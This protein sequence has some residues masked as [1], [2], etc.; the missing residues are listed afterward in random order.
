MDLDGNLSDRL[1]TDAGI[2]QVNR[3]PVRFTAPGDQFGLLGRAGTNGLLGRN[4]FRGPGT[5]VIDLALGK[6]LIF[7][8]RHQLDL[9]VEVFN[10]FNHTHFGMPVN[11][12]LFP[13]LGRSN[14]TRLPARTIQFSGKFNF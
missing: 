1:N 7:T 10:L 11:Q 14:E 9:R 5:A 12:L 4:T 6:A 3:G 13:G 8:D 2:E